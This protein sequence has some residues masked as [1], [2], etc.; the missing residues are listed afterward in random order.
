MTH[1][2]TIWLSILALLIVSRAYADE[3]P[4]WKAGLAKAVITPKV[5]MWLAGHRTPQI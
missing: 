2:R 1:N 4:T 5:P 3:K